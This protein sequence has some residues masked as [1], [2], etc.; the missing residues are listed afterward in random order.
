M[1][2]AKQAIRILLGT[3]VVSLLFVGCFPGFNN[4]YDPDGDKP[5]PLP[6]RDISF[7]KLDTGAILITFTY[8]YE[9]N[10][11][12]VIKREDII[13]ATMSSGTEC[14]DYY[15][16][17]E[18]ASVN[19]CLTGKNDFGRTD[20]SARFENKV[21]P[22][23]V[24]YSDIPDT[25]AYNNLEIFGKVWD[26][27]DVSLLQINSDT[28]DL[29]EDPWQEDTYL[30]RHSVYLEKGSN[31]LNIYARDNSECE[32]DTTHTYTVYYKPENSKTKEIPE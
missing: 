17:A 10:S 11:K 15:E 5:R 31:T 27:S 6:P 29:E 21:P 14:T 2:E 20:V 7:L 30:W 13:V 12:I 9:S 26:S 18:D 23:I 32:S 19:Y 8:E 1:T 22:R 3:L 4:P 24:V 25:T 28:V 16:V